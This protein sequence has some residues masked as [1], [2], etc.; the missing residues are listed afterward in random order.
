[1]NNSA[2]RQRQEFPR[3]IDDRLFRLMVG[4]VI[5][6][7]VIGIDLEGRIFSWNAGAEKLYGY[8]REEIIGESFSTLFTH[9]NQQGGLAGA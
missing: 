7:G 9:E 1:M 3:A 2:R 8:L 5:D 4:S 6:H